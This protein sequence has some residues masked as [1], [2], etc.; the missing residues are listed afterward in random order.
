M[1]PETR[2]ALHKV[3]DELEAFAPVT[4]TFKSMR[5]KPEA[6]A[7]ITLRMAVELI[8]ERADGK[9]DTSRPADP[10]HLAEADVCDVC[11]GHEIEFVY[12]GHGTVLEV[13]CS[14][15]TAPKSK[16]Q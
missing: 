12:G 8:R 1:A 16:A 14:V 9:P 2:A 5:N 7:R 6:A 3:A 11:G 4:S 10:A 13:P 15:C